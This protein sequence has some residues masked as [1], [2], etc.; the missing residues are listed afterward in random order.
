MDFRNLTYKQKNQLLVVAAILFAVISYYGALQNTVDLYKQTT[1]LEERLSLASTAPEQIIK[2][3][4]RL[5]KV[6][7]NLLYNVD[8]ENRQ[9]HLLGLLGKLCKK[10]HVTLKEFPQVQVENESN[11]VIETNVIRVQGSYPNLVKLIYALEQTNKAGKVSSLKYELIK[12][13]RNRREKL[14]ATIYLQIIK[15][16]NHEI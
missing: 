3:K 2:Y 4:K 7:S 6:S 10:H 15:Q 16:N 1:D 11:Y 8:E 14:T 12:D 13:R 5:N 9:D